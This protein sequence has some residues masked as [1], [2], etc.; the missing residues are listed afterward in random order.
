MEETQARV[1]RLAKVP[2]PAGRMSAGEEL[3]R[4]RTVKLPKIAGGSVSADFYLLVAP[5]GN[6]EGASFVRGSE[7][8]RFAGDSLRKVAFKTLFPP[9]SAAHLLRHGILSCSS[10]S[11]CSFVFYPPGLGGTTN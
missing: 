6:V 8:L 2:L 11:G 3:S 4:M 5:G 10:Y 7:T 1:R 9:A